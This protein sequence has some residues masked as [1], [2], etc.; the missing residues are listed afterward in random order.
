MSKCHIVGNH[1]SRLIYDFNN[2]N[3][4]GE[5]NN[6]RKFHTHSIR[7]HQKENISDVAIFYSNENDIQATTSLPRVHMWNVYVMYLQ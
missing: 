5:L 2:T 4:F 6:S 1:M 7:Y 3:I